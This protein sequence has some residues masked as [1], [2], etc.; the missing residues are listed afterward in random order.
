MLSGLRSPGC[1]LGG[2]QRVSA[3]GVNNVALGAG[4]VPF[5]AGDRSLPARLVARPEPGR[6]EGGGASRLPHGTEACAGTRDPRRSAS[7][8]D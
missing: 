7:G 3:A 4:S 5:T 1:S 8:E 6:R 2:A